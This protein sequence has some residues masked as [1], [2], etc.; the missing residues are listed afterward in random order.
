MDNKAV[1]A[2]SRVAVAGTDKAEGLHNYFLRS[3]VPVHPRAGPLDAPI[4]GA[5]LV[6]KHRRNAAMMGRTG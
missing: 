2:D 3:L 4:V 6:C 5:L 1:A